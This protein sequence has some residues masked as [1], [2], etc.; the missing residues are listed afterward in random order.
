MTI[1]SKAHEPDFPLVDFHVHLEGGLTLERA[2]ELSRERGVRFGIVEHGGCGR[3]MSADEDLVRYLEELEG[4]SVYKGMQ[5]EGLDWMG[6]FSGGLVARLDFVLTDA[7]TFPGRDGKPIHL[8]T[9][10]VEIEESQDF[11]DRY[12]DFHVQI[13]SSE[14][15]DI[16]A[17]PTFRPWCIADEF[18]ALWTEERMDR[19]IAAAVQKDVALE[20]NA[21]YEVPSSAFIS[22]AK[23]AGAKFS[24]GSNYHS[25]D[26]G[27]LDYCV[28]MA[29]ECGLQS[30][31]L[32]SP[33]P[34]G[35]K[36]IQVRQPAD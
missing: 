2:L 25:E 31:Q 18:D 36:P 7:L 29:G 20:I 13:I 32:F 19:V 15:I 24:F 8:W 6:C 4:L 34:E 27:K 21:W 1:Q 14:P 30:E 35:M 5:A 12:V 23:S 16:M 33:K 17:N 22:R 26:V 10:E 28:R 11:M 9:P 3:E